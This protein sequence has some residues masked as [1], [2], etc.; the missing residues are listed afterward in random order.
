MSS[1]LL[2][3]AIAYR[4]RGFSVIPIQPRDKRP[5]ISWEPYQTDPP[6]EKQIQEWFAKWPDANVAVVTG[7]VSDCVVIDLDSAQAADE[8]K[9]AITDYD[10]TNVPRSRTGK[11]WQLFFQHPGVP[12]PNRAGVLPNMDVRGDGGYVVAPASIHP[13]GKAYK[14]EVPLT[15]SLPKLPGALFAMITAAVDPASG[16]R[17]RFNTA[18]VLAGVPQG[19]RDQTLF[20]LACK[21]RSADVPRE[22]AE[23]LILE[24]AK[25]CDP[26]FS[27]RTA[28]DKVARVYQRYEPKQAQ[29]K[30]V[31]IWPEFLTAKEILQAPKDPTRWIIENCLP[32]GGASVLVAKPKVGKTTI[33][34]DIAISVARGEPW[35]SRTTQQSPVAYVFLDG[36]LTDIADTFVS[37]GL[38][39]SDPVFIHA[40]SAPADAVAWILAAVKDKGAR[41]VVIDVLQKL[42]RFENINDYS[43]VSTKMEPLLEAARDG[44]CHVMTLH[45]AK[46]DSR[47]DLDAAIGSTAIRGL[48]YTYLFAK[49]LANSERRILSSDQRGGKNFAEVGIGFDKLTGRLFIQGTIDDVEIEEA[50]PLILKFLDGDEQREAEIRKAV[51]MRGWIVGKALR[52]LVKKGDVERNGSGKRGQPFLYSVAPTLMANRE[53][54]KG[55]SDGLSEG[56]LLRGKPDSSPY[57]HSLGNGTPGLAF[58]NQSQLIEKQKKDSSPNIRDEHGT[59]WDEKPISMGSGLESKAFT[60]GSSPDDALKIFGGEIRA[61]NRTRQSH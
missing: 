46:K 10:L 20:K 51:P 56:G 44:H 30:Q 24:A 38:R 8:L 52:S 37:L 34:A 61:N 33:A 21:L 49:R 45:H 23:T 57:L 4:R 17:E 48:C 13:N 53:G 5:L 39:E 1:L 26:P 15:A 58:E 42:C 50:T 41:L 35:L 43:E 25:N 19:Q 18:Q 6:T 3:T 14:W 16:P 9:H 59:S 12:V 47:D 29:A 60:N 7:A 40:G 22:M 31:A 36:P 55:H 54:A 28:L 27:E 11:G 32:V 2:D